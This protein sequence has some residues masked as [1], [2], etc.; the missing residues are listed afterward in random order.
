MTAGGPVVAG[1]TVVAALERAGFERRGQRGSHVKLREPTTGRTVIVPLHP[2]LA[3]GTLAS[4][5]R[6]AGWSLPELQQHLARHHREPP[7]LKR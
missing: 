5:C 4:I 3:R 2:E 6:Q 1:R 7:G